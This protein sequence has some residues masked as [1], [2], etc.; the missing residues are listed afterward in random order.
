MVL[1]TFVTVLWL[2]FFASTAFATFAGSNGRI[3]YTAPDG[4]I[5]TIKPN[6]RGDRP[7]GPVSS[8]APAWGPGGKRLAFVL[9][10]E[11]WNTW[12]NIYTM[13]ADGNDTQQI[14]ADIHEDDLAPSYSPGGR[15]I[16][17][18]TEDDTGASS[19][20][21][22]DPDPTHPYQHFHNVKTRDP[23]GYNLSGAVWAPNGKITY[24]LWHKA[25]GTVTSNIW[26][27]RPDGTHQHRLI[28]RGATPVY[29]PNG[30]RF[31]FV[32]YKHGHPR[33]L[34]ADANGSNVRKPP[35]NQVVQRM[36]RVVAYSPNGKWLLV[37]KE[38]D[39]SGT[40]VTNLMRLS[41]GSCKREPI[42][43]GESD[44]WDADWQAQPQS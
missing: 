16:L 30:K 4:R 32:R 36:G 21:I 37:S 33:Y 25:R 43:S 9:G 2:A 15:R 23:E 34:L 27:T 8:S 11:Q 31:L 12:A 44:V 3:A 38:H 22:Y 14:T 17:F 42:V 10:G 40:F 41:L 13:S 7:I 6:G 5:H 24:V 19:V 18:V 20:H 39:R 29:A 26:T 28:R 35:C 1:G